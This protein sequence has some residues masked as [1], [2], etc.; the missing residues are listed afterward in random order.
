MTTG[1]Q[2]PKLDDVTQLEVLTWFMPHGERQAIKQ[3]LC[4]E[5]RRHFAKLLFDLAQTIREAPRTYDQDGQGMEAVAHLHY[6]GG[7]ADA[8]ITELDRGAEDDEP[9]HFQMQA[10]GLVC[11]FGDRS[12]AELGYVSIPELTRAGLELDLY[13]QP[14]TIREIKAGA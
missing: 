2:V 5:E 13:W 4:G 3:A 7:S 9:E 12:E 1:I 8:W 11:L 10:F 6:F 14:K